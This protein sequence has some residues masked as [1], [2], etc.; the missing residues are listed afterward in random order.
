MRLIKILS[1]KQGLLSR[2]SNNFVKLTLLALLLTMVMPMASPVAAMS[3]YGINDTL[4]N[5][6]SG[7]ISNHTITFITA[8]GMSPED[9]IQFEFSSGF[10]LVGA[11]VLSFQNNSGSD[12][13]SISDYSDNI[14]DQSVVITRNGGY[15]FPSGTQFRVIIGTVINPTL[16]GNYSIN[17]STKYFTTTIDNGTTSVTITSTQ[18]ASFTI[19]ELTVSPEE[20]YVDDSVQI[21]VIVE[22]IGETAS[23]YQEIL[24]IDNLEI[25][26]RNIFVNAGEQEMEVFNSKLMSVGVHTVEINGETT[27]FEVKRTPSTSNNPTSSKQTVFYV[28]MGVPIYFVSTISTILALRAKKTHK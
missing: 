4:T 23:I 9:T 24:K 7:A 18:P 19:K 15:L 22:N 11:K 25:E 1:T 3:L 14:A 28:A 20:I 26:A 5:N 12:W 8:S 13:N 16:A 17:L 21:K 10:N 27:T 6:K 2:R